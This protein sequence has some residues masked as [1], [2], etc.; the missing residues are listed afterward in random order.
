MVIT[1]IM[2]GAGAWERLSVRL[3]FAEK[4]RATSRH[5]APHCGMSS[6]TPARI[7]MAIAG[8]WTRISRTVINR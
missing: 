1:A 8:E 3:E 2:V 5:L 6:E 4:A 7:G